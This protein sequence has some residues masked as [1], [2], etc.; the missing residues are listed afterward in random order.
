MELKDRARKVDVSKMSPE[1]VDNLSIQ[2]GSKVRDICDEAANKANAI[3]EIYGMKAKIA[4]SFN[5]IP[6]QMENKFEAPKKRGRKPKQNN[7][8]EVE[9]STKKT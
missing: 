3:L 5:D 8:K 7:L 9:A 6:K 4:I 1:E 2:I